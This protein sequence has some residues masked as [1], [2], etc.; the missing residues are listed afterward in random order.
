MTA[1][2]QT[3]RVLVEIDLNTAQSQPYS[4][5]WRQLAQVYQPVY[6]VDDIIICV[7]QGQIPQALVNHLQ[8]ILAHLDISNSFVMIA[9][10]DQAVSQKTELARQFSTDEFAI[11]HCVR[12]FDRQT[13]D[14]SEPTNFEIPD[15]ICLAP[16]AR[17]EVKADGRCKPCCGMEASI[18]DAHGIDMNIQSHSLNEIYH[19]PFLR[20]LRQQL[21]SGQRP[22]VCNA[23]WWHE[24]HD[25]QSIRQHTAWDLKQEQFN[26]D[27]HSETIHNLRSWHLSLGNTCN[28]K[29]RTCGPWSSSRWAAEI[30]QH[31]DQAAP[32]LSVSPRLDWAEQ[33]DLPLWQDL[34]STIAHVTELRFTGG[35]PLLIKKQF[36]LV[37]RIAATDRASQIS[38]VYTSNGTVPFPAEY[39][40]SLAHFRS[41][42]ISL[43][44]DDIGPRFEYQRHGAKWH[45]IEKNTAA[46]SKLKARLPNLTLKVN[47]TVSIMN[48]LYLPEL[49]AWLEQ[50]PFEFVRLS[51]LTHPR[52]LSIVNTTAD[53][54]QAVLDRL[55]SR[56]WSPDMQTQIESICR[57][58]VD[59]KCTDGTDFCHHIR[60][61]DLRRHENFAESHEE[62][63][64]LM[65]Y[66]L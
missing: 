19:S 49:L 26:I 21:L 53:H 64:T 42:S 17:L 58:L 27:W 66:R 2:T 37:Q 15:S 60:Q 9:T 33:P 32:L 47:C 51:V 31:S 12:H 43:S 13:D 3:K 57:T 18:K 41:V 45:D 28:L 25:R 59:A 8:K 52:V 40:A 22:E 16:W 7:Y 48:V 14:I 55:T 24:Q 61:I 6:H 20:N 54:R 34:E 38:L 62:T 11:S 44:I 1:M 46:F 36:E 10:D 30:L 63:A 35:E 56:T 39:Q 4:W 23:C 65:R 29:C 50:Q 5:L